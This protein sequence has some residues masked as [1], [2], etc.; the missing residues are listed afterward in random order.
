VYTLKLP[1][2]GEGI[3]EG[4]IVQ[5]H[6]G[7]GQQVEQDAP[8]VDVLTDKATV[9]IPSPVKGRLVRLGGK[10]G[11]IVKV[12]QVLA[13]LDTGAAEQPAAQ[14]AAPPAPRASATTPPAAAPAPARTGPIPAAPA[15]RR[16]ARELGLDLSQVQGTGPGG[17]VTPEDLETFQS[18]EGRTGEE[19]LKGEAGGQEAGLATG[20]AAQR[21]TASG[22]ASP[23]SNRP[24]Q[25][26][27]SPEQVL[28]ASSSPSMNPSSSG[29]FLFSPE[30]LPDYAQ[31]GPVEK[32]P[33][34]GV[35][36]LTARRMVTAATLVPHVA[37]FDEA[38]VSSLE[39]LR[40]RHKARLSAQGG[41]PLSLLPFVVQAVTRALRAHPKL[42]ASVD[43]GREEIVLKKFYHLGVAVASPRGLV[44]PVIRDAE[45]RS[46]LELAA[47]IDRLARAAREDKLEAQELRGGTFTITNI[48]P[49]GGLAA[50]P[51][52][53]YPEVAILA[54][55]RAQDR[56]VVRD[57]QVVVRRI[58]PLVLSFDHRLIDGADAARFVNA[59]V[60]MLEEPEQLLLGG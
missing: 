32:E 25:S 33:L 30:L 36:R 19:F 46:P 38:D 39:A 10:P 20:Q 44:V 59:V 49:I 18:K 34:R 22:P 2:L 26:Q 27:P 37:H 23:E 16:L 56:P 24:A 55:G 58:L 21:V 40:Q 51:I 5:W 60:H 54:L 50:T 11:D 7:E 41:P 1:D 48:G 35:R 57:G 53:N 9:T 15:T 17:R 14:P 6:V 13:E 12:G 29:S 45:R 47:E 43:L 4:E 42:N 31:Q 28:A 8:L 52:V 3:H